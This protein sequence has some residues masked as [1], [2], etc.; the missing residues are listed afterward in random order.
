MEIIE[1]ISARRAYRNL[2]PEPLPEGT[3]ERIVQAGHLA[4][5][6]FNNQSW[7]IVAAS[8]EALAGLREALSEAN[9]WAAKA[10]LI[11][12]VSAKEA[13]DCRLD[14]GRDYFLFD[15]GLCAMNMITQATAEGLVAHPIA[16]FNP[17]KAKSALGIDKDRVL[18][19]LIIVAKRAD[20][21]A[22]DN[23]AMN[24]SQKSSEGAPRVRKPLEEI[25]RFL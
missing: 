12:A 20:G 24:A 10:P 22:E 18:I 6:C 25:A 7:R 5:S 2:S 17:K 16:G 3:A 23:E 13:D 8:G 21:S 19:T 14:D 15:A 1:A 11:I 4:P 9:A